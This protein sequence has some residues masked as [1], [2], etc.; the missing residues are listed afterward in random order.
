MSYKPV[1]GRTK[2]EKSK[3]KNK[4]WLQDGEIRMQLGLSSPPEALNPSLMSGIS[5][6]Q[7]PRLPPKTTI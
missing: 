4:D 3:R 7:V 6:L 1:S 5:K 2:G